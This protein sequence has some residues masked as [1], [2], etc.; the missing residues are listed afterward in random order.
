MEGGVPTRFGIT[1]RT[2]LVVL[3]PCISR[4]R[5][6]SFLLILGVL[7]DDSGEDTGTE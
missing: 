6:V 5:F 1:M 4:L 3:R 7:I 2:A